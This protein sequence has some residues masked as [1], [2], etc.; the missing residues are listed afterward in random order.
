[1][2]P[3]YFRLWVPAKKDEALLVL[4]RTGQFGIRKALWQAIC[5]YFEAKHNAFAPSIHPLI[6]EQVVKQNLER[7][8]VTK[9]RFVRFGVRSDIA[10]AY[11]TQDHVEEIGTMQLVVTARRGK[12]LPL[13]GRLKDVVSGKRQLQNMIELQD[14]PYD[15]VK[16]ELNVNG[17]TRTVDLGNL[18]RAR[19]YYDVDKDVKRGANGHPLFDSIDKVAEE[20]L[21][22]I[23]K[24]VYLEID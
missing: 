9:I 12:T 5:K 23:R 13:V 20:L 14:F 24:H 19:A 4:Q 8:H 22:D 17:R 10:D 7:G 2:L 3:F 16:V 6:P 1:M 21:T 11:D 18:G 15:T